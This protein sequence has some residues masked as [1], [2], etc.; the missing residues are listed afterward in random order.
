LLR[1]PEIRL[2]AAI[3]W[4][5]L[6]VSSESFGFS[7]CAF[8]LCFRNKRKSS[9]CHRRSVVFLDKEKRLFPGPNHPRQNHQKQPICLP[10]C[11]SL[12]LST[13]NNQLV[14]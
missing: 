1:H 9:R 7:A 2:L 13:E 3:S 5:K 10:V 4:I 6:I 8:D 11:R 14:S 12:D